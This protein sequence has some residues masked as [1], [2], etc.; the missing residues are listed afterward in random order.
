M[1]SLPVNNLNRVLREDNGTV[2]CRCQLDG[3]QSL[4][5]R[6]EPQLRNCLDQIGLRACL[7]GLVSVANWYRRI[8]LCRS[9]YPL[10]GGPGLYKKVGK[11]V[12]ILGKILKVLQK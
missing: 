3:P 9:C 4:L 8:C 10:E 6:G 11:I 7:R 2:S 5:G 1:I 12:A